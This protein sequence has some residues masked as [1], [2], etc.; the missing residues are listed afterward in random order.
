MTIF[1]V[2]DARHRRR[3]VRAQAPVGVDPTR[4]SIARVYDAFLSG[5]DNYEVDR[6]VLRGVQKAA[7]EAQELATENR[8]FLIRACR[9]LAGQTD[10]TQFLDCGSGLPTAENT[11][12]VVQRI[13][14]DTRSFMSTTTR[15]YSRTAARCWRRTT[16]PISCRRT[17]S[18]RRR[19][20]RTRWSGGYIDFTRPL[21]LL[22]LGTLHHYNG[23]RERPAEIMREYIDALPSG[24]YVAISHFLDPE[25]EHSEM[26]RNMEDMFLHS[27][28]GSGTFRTRA[29]LLELFEGLELVE[30]GLV[31]CADWWPDGPRLKPLNPVAVLHRRRRRPQALTPLYVT[32]SH[33]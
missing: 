20:W 15:W 12:Q 28:M 33:S 4:A 11:H 6:E 18:S 22:Q 10:I 29:E 26:A 25:N 14:P 16:R 5:K 21:A 31:L 30:P 8:G 19:S 2:S 27:P 32:P 17:S 23:P 3:P 1:G 7:P 24:S 13:N 9:F